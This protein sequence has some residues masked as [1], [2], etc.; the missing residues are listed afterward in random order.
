[1]LSEVLQRSGYDTAAFVSGYP[2]LRRSGLA[3]GFTV[4]DDMMQDK[5]FGG[6]WKVE[7]RAPQTAAAF[8]RWWNARRDARPWFAWVHF[9]DPHGP[10]TPLPEYASLFIGDGL[11]TRDA[12]LD[13]PGNAPKPPAWTTIAGERQDRQHYISQYDAEIR[14]ADDGLKAI[15]SLLRETGRLE[16]TIIVVSADHGEYL[17]EHDRWFVHDDLYSQSLLIPMVFTGPGVP[18]GGR[19]DSITESIDVAP[20][21]LSL[22]GIAPPA[23]MMGKKLFSDDGAVCEHTT[24]LVLSESPRPGR[25][26][27]IGPALQLIGPQPPAGLYDYRHDPLGRNDLIGELPY[28]LQTM[29]RFAADTIG[30][31][32]RPWTADGASSAAQPDQPAPLSGSDR[33][34][35]KSLG[36]VQ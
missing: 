14:M 23:S 30:R 22:A 1:M 12:V 27:V 36:Y 5:L 7:R 9:Y 19:S 25:C 24:G 34:A 26:S 6:T 31:A 20:T 18:R 2:L 8:R 13:A 17:G 33:D 10:Y 16:S 21:L 3:A 28:E 11:E 15:V 4:Y 35:L 29:G 32:R